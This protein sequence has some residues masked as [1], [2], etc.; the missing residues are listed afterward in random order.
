M[1]NKHGLQRAI[2]ANVKRQ[3]RKRCGFGCVI[4][5]CAI[6]EYDHFDPEYSDAT[7]HNSD[8]IALL[9]P[10]HHAL[11]G[12]KLLSKEKYF[13]A[14]KNP[15]AI[16]LSTAYSEWENSKFTPTIIIG[17]KIF[18][19]GTSV[20]SVDGVLLLGFTAPE[21]PNSP[22]RLHFRFFDRNENE[23]FSII[24][25]EISAYTSSFDV[26]ASGNKWVVRS[27]L[28][29]V[30]LKIEFKPPKFIIIEKLH[31]RYKGWELL[32]EKEKFDLKYN[33][34]RN[35]S[36]SGPLEIVGPCLFNLEGDGHVKMNDMYIQGLGSKP[37]STN[38]PTMFK[39]PIY[40][41]VEA[42]DD[43]LL[44]DVNIAVIQGLNV[45]PIY[46]SEAEAIRLTSD[47]IPSQFKLQG[48]YQKGFLELLK[49]AAIP[50]GITK[51]TLNLNANSKFQYHSIQLID[52]EQFIID[53][54]KIISRNE[55]CPCNSGLRYKN[56]HGKL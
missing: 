32:A 43:T 21:E 47:K 36:F 2:S 30:D 42:N 38:I 53:N 22:P 13:E 19:G 52:L 35:L 26:E 3:V 9:C 54:S 20:L 24:E 45:L 18:T 8:G 27:K 23:V 39:W 25:N 5:G 37:K 51:A 56:C 34:N 29:A 55:A 41:Y 16:E 50:K 28:Y 44:S 40:V 10:T 1:T 6:Y 14:I 33:G 7:E 12:R 15:K 11:K 31:F 4:C 49:N 48:F 17:Q 46:L